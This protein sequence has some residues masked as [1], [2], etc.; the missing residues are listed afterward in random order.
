MPKSLIDGEHGTLLL[1]VFIALSFASLA[2]SRP[3]GLGAASGAERMVN[4]LAEGTPRLV[5]ASVVDLVV[6]ADEGGG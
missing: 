2:S 3:K 6:E 4:G 5:N 1:L